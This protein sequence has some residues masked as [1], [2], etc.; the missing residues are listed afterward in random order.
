MADC[1]DV[2]VEQTD[3][4]SSSTSSL[5]LAMAA[6]TKTH[7]ASSNPMAM[8]YPQ[9][10][11]DLHPLLLNQR[12]RSANEK[13]QTNI[14]GSDPLTLGLVTNPLHKELLRQSYRQKQK[15]SKRDPATEIDPLLI[16]SRTVNTFPDGLSAGEL[17]PSDF[18]TKPRKSFFC[19]ACGKSFKFQTSLLRHNNKVHI[20][21]YQCPTCNRVF[22]RQAYLDV[23]TS[24]QGSS[25][26]QGSAYNATLTHSN[27]TDPISNLV[28]VNLK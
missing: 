4:P 27:K 1:F 9:I 20:S 14:L 21:K 24:K 11:Y 7:G 10:S 6:Y 8:F 26:Y 12:R 19:R 18:S 22:S 28:N 23:H 16:P 2:D 3:E 5:Q 17:D 13:L 25:C 15:I